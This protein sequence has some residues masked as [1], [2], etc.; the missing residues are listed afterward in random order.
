MSKYGKTISPHDTIG[1][2][3]PDSAQQIDGDF[4]IGDS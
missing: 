1:M 3:K 2:L 4:Y